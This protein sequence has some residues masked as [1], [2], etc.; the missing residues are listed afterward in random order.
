[1]DKIIDNQKILLGDDLKSELQ[2]GSKLKIAASCF[3]LFAFGELKEELSKIEELQFIFTSPAFSKGDY[4]TD[5]G[6]KERREYFI[7]KE[8][9]RADEIGKISREA[10]LF[11]T[12]FEIRLRNKM[13]LRAIAKE[14]AAW[15]RAKGKF[16]SNITQGQLNP[17]ITVEQPDGKKV[18]YFPTPQEFSASGLGYAKNNDMMTDIYK[19]DT[20]A[21]FWLS[22]FNEIFDNDAKVE[23][24]TEEVVNN[25]STAYKENSPEF[26]YYIIL[27]NIF[28][29]Y[30][31]ELNED[32]MPNEATG[33]K[34]T[35]LW[36][37]LYEFQR[38]GV[39][40][41]IN[42]LEKHNG[43]ILADSVG[44]GK[45]FTALAV[46]LYYSLRNK[47]VLVLCPKRLE[48]NWTQYISNNKSNLFYTD[49]IRYEVLFHTDL[50]RVGKGAGGRDLV[51]VNWGCYDLVV[52]DESHN[53][54][55]RGSGGLKDEDNLDA[56]ACGRYN[57][58]LNEVM[59][60]GYNTKVLMLSATPV[61]NRYIDL[62]NQLQLAYA[63]DRKRFDA[64]LDTDKSIESIFTQ[65]QRVYNAWEKLPLTE[66]KNSDLINKL[67]VDFRILLDS[68]TIA[69]SRKTVQKHYDM[70]QIGSFPERRRPQNYEPNL[71]ERQD[72]LPYKDIVLLIGQLSY[73]AYSAVEDLQPSRL[74]EYE[75][76]YSKSEGY[77]SLK[78]KSLGLIN[79]MRSTMLKR[80]ESSVEAF[81]STLLEIN[82]YN[83]EIIAQLKSYLDGTLPYSQAFMSKRHSKLKT[84]ELEE[85]DEFNT[86]EL[87]VWFKDM[88]TRSFKT[89]LEND[90][91]ILDR[92][93]F[94]A[95]KVDVE[96]DLKLATLKGVISD[97]IKNPFN[98]VRTEDNPDAKAPNKKLLIFSAFSDTADYLYE[99]LSAWILKEYGLHSALIVG[100][101][102][103]STVKNCSK[104][105]NDLITMFSPVSKGRAKAFEWIAKSKATYD[106]H[107]AKG[108]KVSGYVY[109]QFNALADSFTD[110]EIIFA[111]DCVS[112]GQNM[113]DG[114]TCINYDIHWN[115]VRIV[116][117]FGRID[118]L[119]SINK[120][121]QLICFWPPIKLDEHLK[122]TA[123]VKSR[124]VIADHASTADDNLLNP[125]EKLDDYREQQIKSLKNGENIE[126]EDA[127]GGI[128]IADL[129]LNDFKIDAIEYKKLY[130]NLA[131][132]P[133]GLHTVISRSETQGLQAGV[134][135][136][137]LNTNRNIQIR[138]QN[139][140]HPYYLVYIDDK[141]KPIKTHLEVKQILDIVKFHCKGQA[142][143]IQSACNKF[144]RETQDGTDMNKYNKILA[145]A[146]S[147]II[148]KKQESDIDSLFNKGGTTALTGDIKGLDD[149]E[150]IAFVV[151]K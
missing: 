72:V 18:A 58:L 115:P 82:A 65:A 27:S 54:R 110:I 145:D 38:D 83:K 44:L 89:K 118:R 101:G 43:C 125:D 39:T 86:K 20:M 134:I 100:D 76:K 94:E 109:K 50:G 114:D 19:S 107:L 66:R 151:V 57:F 26:V 69:R 149:F 68:V 40:Q 4:I 46:I 91:A 64:S 8:E 21:G 48:Q 30:L 23:E 137:L 32:N 120:E 14:C 126:L 2:M 141:G 5:S 13:N 71:T 7:P 117:R 135:F 78:G 147:S 142:N 61:N 59:K 28:A 49:R 150:L 81:R 75:R 45:T 55:N 73:A 41:V 132:T 29:D 36:E 103:K 85:F 87:I 3:T 124:M 70:S 143:P 96:D 128:S 31:D 139:L 99:N 37:A 24:V 97:K 25:I 51:D 16:R 98:F 102:N 11:G 108:G 80:L 129:G 9:Q 79:F 53:F 77:V 33:F 6:K 17:F 12:D 111:S 62:R 131:R 84:I 56:A 123:R 148:D 34:Q 106:N 122:L 112:E 127:K 138:S 15:V 22:Q 95:N 90:I 93:F 67:S 63:Q 144:N 146:V 133:K 119:G 105:T 116:Q 74:N 88:D 1:V 10:S 35:K 42:K 113:Q 52:I 60:G 104:K 130:G 47:S 92:L 140:L 136:L 121:V